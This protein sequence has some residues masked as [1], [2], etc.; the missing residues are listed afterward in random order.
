MQEKTMAQ[1]DRDA[2]QIV[3]NWTTGNALLGWLPGSSLIFT[4]ADTAMITQVANA[5]DV[6]A[7]DM[8]HVMSTLTGAL[9]GAFASGVIVESIGLIPV[10]G[11]A[12]KSAA[13]AAKA[14]FIGTEIRK[15]FRERSTLKKDSIEIEIE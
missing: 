6:N 11:W 1:A 3:A 10:I 5:Y 2:K 9:A 14:N 13:M 4:A 8:E 12:I 15:Y 7:F